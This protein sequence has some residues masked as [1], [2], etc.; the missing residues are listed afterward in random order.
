MDYRL[1]K[2]EV[3][4]GEGPEKEDVKVERNLNGP[5]ILAVSTL[6]Q[7]AENP[8]VKALRD[9]IT[10]WHLSYLS[11]KEMRTSPEAGPQ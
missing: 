1:G 4:T 10:G 2:G 9:F 5:D 7:L 8:R 11:A 3:I 6:G